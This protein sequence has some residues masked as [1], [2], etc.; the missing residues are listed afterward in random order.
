MQLQT[1]FSCWSEAE[2][3]TKL[4]SFICFKDR[5]D[6]TTVVKA[7]LSRIQR[8]LLAKLS[9]GTLPLELEIGRYT[10]VDEE[11]H[12]CRIC[13]TNQVE[14]EY[15]FLFDC[16]PLQWVRSG[17]Y[18]DHVPNIGWFMLLPDHKKVMYLLSKD[19]VKYFAEFVE[20][21]YYARR[22]IIYKPRLIN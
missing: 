20:N 9:S 10:N 11:D 21:L 14:T 19:M 22:N 13:N 17:F 5:S 2:C 15:H 6:T 4:R 3:K 18:V 8:S 16:A 12:L 7:N 1:C